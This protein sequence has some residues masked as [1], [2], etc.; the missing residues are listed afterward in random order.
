M[1]LFKIITV[2]AALSL[3]AIF[4]WAPWVTFLEPQAADVQVRAF[5]SDTHIRELF[6]RVPQLSQVV[7]IA[8]L[9][10]IQDARELF[11]D[12]EIRELYEMSG[13]QSNLT[14]FDL[15]FRIAL[16]QPF[17]RVLLILLPFLVI[18]TFLYSFVSLRAAA[19]SPARS[20]GMAWA[21]VVFLVL[22]LLLWY[23]P[24]L[25][26]LGE[27]DNFKLALACMLLGTQTGFGVWLAL[28]ALL[29]IGVGTLLESLAASDKPDMDFQDSFEWQT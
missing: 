24:S 6:E 14:G 20:V 21:A 19:N 23:V 29:G 10:S 9:E 4:L 13:A 3:G 15:A 25:Y 7:G 2:A 16:V 12:P 5:L 26:T 28:L 8:K 17:L 18:I 11:A 1:S 22:I 27:Q